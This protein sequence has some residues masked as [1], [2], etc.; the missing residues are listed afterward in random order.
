MSK[1]LSL[2]IRTRVLAG[3]VMSASSSAVRR[4]R[5]KRDPLARSG[6]QTGDARPKALGG[7]R[8][9][10]PIEARARGHPPRRRARPP[11]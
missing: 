10:G 3:I 6:A 1:A 5:V 4:E 8:R 9:S 11:M 2:D 7:D